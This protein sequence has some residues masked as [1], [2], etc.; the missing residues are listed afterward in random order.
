MTLADT[1]NLAVTV[2]S[3]VFVPAALLSQIFEDRRQVRH[4]SV[5]LFDLLLPWYAAACAVDTFVL[6]AHHHPLRMTEDAAQAV[7]WTWI[8]LRRNKG[9]RDRFKRRVHDRVVVRGAKLVVVP[10][11]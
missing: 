1:F 11:G 8:W 5:V 7:V 10:Q 3:L 4:P 6:M 9:K 2:S